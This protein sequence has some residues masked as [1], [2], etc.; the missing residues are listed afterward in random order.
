MSVVFPYSTICRIVG[1]EIET[2]L[3]VFSENEM[4]FRNKAKK[5]LYVRYNRYQR[6]K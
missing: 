5:R 3:E 6:M 4:Y 1:H 2:M